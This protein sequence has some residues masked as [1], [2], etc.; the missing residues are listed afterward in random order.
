LFEWRLRRRDLA[1]PRRNRLKRRG[2][3]AGDVLKDNHIEIWGWIDG[4]F[5]LSTSHGANGNAPAGYDFNSNTA[6]LNQAVLYIERIPD[7]VQQDHLDWGF[8]FVNLYGT[9]YRE[10]TM[11]GIFSNQLTKYNNLYSTEAVVPARLI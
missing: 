7:T 5:N 10:V 3:P 4:G 9:D 11:Q 2:T 6:Q 8:R 1:S